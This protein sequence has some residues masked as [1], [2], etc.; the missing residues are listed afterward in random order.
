MILFLLLFAVSFRFY[1]LN[2][3]GRCSYS[4]PIE[5]V[6]VDDEVEIYISIVA[7]KDFCLWLDG[8]DNLFQVLQ[9]LWFNFCSL[10]QEDDVAELHLLDNERCQ[11]F[12]IDV[13][14]HQVGTVGKF[15]FHAE[16]I[17]NGHDAVE[18]QDAVLDVLRAE[19]W[20]RTDGLGD[21]SW[22]ADTA[23]FNDDIVKALHIYNLLQL[24]H[25]VHFQGAADTAVLQRNKR[26][27]FLTHYATFLN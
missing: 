4:L 2:P 1:L 11:V 9:L 27:V 6:G 21:R 8:T 15:I 17:Y 10:V 5:L 19:R 20:D 14:F 26:I 13:L 25:K 12:F 23:G 24:L 7:L 18:A 3:A 22:L 16:G